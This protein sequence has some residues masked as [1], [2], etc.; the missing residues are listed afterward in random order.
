LKRIPG[1][2]NRAVDIGTI[3]I[4]NIPFLGAGTGQASFPLTK[5]FKEVIA[6]D[7]SEGQIKQAIESNKYRNKHRK[8]RLLFQENLRFEKGIAEKIDLPDK[9]ADLI[10][11]AQGDEDIIL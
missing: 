10:V 1:E 8:F 3:Y 5:Y 9:S 7:P 2:R 11:S 6:F 4:Y